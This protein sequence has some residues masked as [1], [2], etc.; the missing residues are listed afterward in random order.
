M[1]K[2]IVKYTKTNN[3]VIKIVEINNKK[4][5]EIFYFD[6]VDMKNNIENLLELLTSSTKYTLE[7]VF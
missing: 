4:Q 5:N 7:R 1:K 3:E 6:Y 2:N